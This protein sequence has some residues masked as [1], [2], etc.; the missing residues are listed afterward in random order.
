[1][2]ACSRSNASKEHP[3]DLHQCHSAFDSQKSH[4][5][6]STT[7]RPVQPSLRTK[8]GLSKVLVL[9]G[10]QFDGPL[11]ESSRVGL[12]NQSS[13]GIKTKVNDSLMAIQFQDITQQQI[14]VVLKSLQMFEEYLSEKDCFNLMKEK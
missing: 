4:R 8:G 12:G 14:E 6:D 9:S 3:T 2:N 7:A 5:S 11:L 10:V 13:T 1:M